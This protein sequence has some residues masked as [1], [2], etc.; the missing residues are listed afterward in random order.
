[1]KQIMAIVFALGIGLAA[2]AA[3]QAGGI[4]TSQAPRLILVAD[5]CGAGWHRGEYGRCRRNGA[6]AQ[7]GPGWHRGPYGGCR[8]DYEHPD[9]HA[10]PRGFHLGPYGRCRPD[11]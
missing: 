9:R 10:C 7:C 4:P 1:M 5:G 3:S 2:P 11:R 8:R 6:E